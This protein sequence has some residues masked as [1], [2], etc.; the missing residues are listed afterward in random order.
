MLRLPG[1]RDA[2]EKLYPMI[3]Y[4]PVDAWSEGNT[5]DPYYNKYSDS[6]FTLS[7]ASGAT[8]T[9][10]FNGTAVYLY[11]AKRGNH[12][13]YNVTLDGMTTTSNG[14]YPD[15]GL[16][17]TPLF[18]AA[19]LKNTLH[20]VTLTNAGTNT[21]RALDFLDLDFITWTAD[22]GT[23]SENA[24]E[25]TIQDTSTQFSYT[26]TSE[27]NTN[28]TY[29]SDFFGQS[30]HATTTAGAYT[31]LTFVGD[32][33]QIFG[34]VGPQVSPYTVE[35]DGGAT[36]T[37]NAT[38]YANY[39]QV[40]LYYADNLG[41][42]SHSV[43]ITNQPSLSGESLNINYALVDTV[44]SVNSGSPSGGKSGI[45]GGA[46]AGIVIGALAL[47]A[48]AGLIFT[49]LRRRRRQQYAMNHENPLVFEPFP[50][51][52]TAPTTTER[53]IT[54]SDY[55][56]STNPPSSSPAS[57]TS[58]PTPASGQGSQSQYNHP[59]LTGVHNPEVAG[60]QYS[61][62]QGTAPSARPL[63]QPRPSKAQMAA[64]R[65]RDAGHVPVDG[66]MPPPDY[67]QAIGP[68]RS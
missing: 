45:S 6:T 36:A 49:L 31:T 27:W 13:L 16:F 51:P 1:T 67:S 58:P 24:S 30:G 22:F 40:L 14:E 66:E 47:L 29:V 39:Q 60:G 53:T 48:I 12:G 8:A 46:I 50:H 59:V 28:P 26:P 38:K 34:T 61:P 62:V 15:P 57:A 64:E 43:K 20:T 7:V 55:P 21:N 54:S 25:T 37:Y 33:V 23:S 17:Q 52:A 18:S 5:S 3:S 35:L 63:P 4:Q 11:G 65:P 2:F 19:N 56:L 68:L 10:S 41:A 9:F 44:P 32:A 42:G